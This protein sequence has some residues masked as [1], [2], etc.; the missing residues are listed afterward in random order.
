MTLVAEVAGVDD[1]GRL[2]QVALAAPLCSQ[3]RNC[4]ICFFASSF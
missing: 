3:A 4:F 1:G 2:Y